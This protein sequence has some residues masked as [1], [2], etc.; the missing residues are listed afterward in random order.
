MPGQRSGFAKIKTPAEKIKKNKLGGLTQLTYPEDLGAY[1][2]VIN[3]QEYSYTVDNAQP[4]KIDTKESII[5]P[6]PE[7]LGQDYTASIKDEELNPLGQLIATTVAD[8][9]AVPNDGTIVGAVEGSVDAAGSA[10]ND[11]VGD[12]NSLFDDPAKVGSGIFRGLN[13]AAKLLKKRVAPDFAVSA[14]EAGAG[15]IYNPANISAFKGT[16]VRKH[17]LNWKLIPRN[18]SESAKLTQIIQLIR[19]KMHSQLAGLDGEGEFLQEYPDIIS[20]ALITPDI[21]NS[22]FYKPG[23]ISKFNV[24]HTG[25]SGLNFFQGTGSP[26]EYNLNLEFSELDFITRDDFDEIDIE[27]TNTNSGAGGSGV[28]F[29]GGGV[30]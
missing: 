3:F 6:L 22:I 29:G 1:G 24:D 13:Q 5:L 2:F 21:N 17:K 26:V 20:C 8:D 14:V 27:E 12:K 4:L 15:N 11:V 9:F 16:P 7:K 10:F 23:L 18:K 25:Q 30:R 28:G 19:R